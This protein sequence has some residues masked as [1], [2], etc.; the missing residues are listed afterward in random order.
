MITANKNKLLWSYITAKFQ[1]IS[2]ATI[3]ILVYIFYLY[4]LRVA[5]HLHS[6]IL[7]RYMLSATAAIR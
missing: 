4:H 5:R 2:I 1:H 6:L 7:R 3:F